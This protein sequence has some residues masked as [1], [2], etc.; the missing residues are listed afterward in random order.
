MLRTLIAAA[1]LTAAIVPASAQ[2]AAPPARVGLLEC[3]VSGGVGL[4][5]T[6]SKALSCRFTPARGGGPRERYVGTVRKYGLDVGATT[7]GQIA[8]A[9]LA[10]TNT[11]QRGALAGTYAGAGAEATAGAGL[12]ANLLV[13]GSNRTI[14]LQPLS[15]SAQTGLNLAAG[16]TE[17]ELAPAR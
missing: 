12:G 1:A 7:K 17:L 15:V 3:S 6:S 13:G 4:I 9:V 2:S 11:W 5:I 8:W 14:S 16:V 10:P